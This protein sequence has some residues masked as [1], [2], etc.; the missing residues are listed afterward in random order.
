MKWLISFM[1]IFSVCVRAENLTSSFFSHVDVEEGVY[2][3]QTSTLSIESDW[4]MKETAP[5]VIDCNEESEFI[6]NAQ[7]IQHSVIEYIEKSLE[8]CSSLSEVEGY[9]SLINWNNIGLI[10]DESFGTETQTCDIQYATC[11]LNQTFIEVNESLFNVS[12][13]KG[14]DGSQSGKANVFAYSI[15]SLSSI[16][17]SGSGGKGGINDLPDNYFT[18]SY[19]YTLEDASNNPIDSVEAKTP[20]V[21]MRK[22]DFFPILSTGDAPEGSSPDDVNQFTYGVYG[23]DSSLLQILKS[24]TQ[25]SNQ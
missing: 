20:I 17:T 4:D 6:Y 3:S 8:D 22:V 21:K 24:A 13:E 14:E 23:L 19:C 5:L 1:F 12:P 7:V 2:D 9:Y 15:K 10:Q 25:E 16:N 18:T 11:D